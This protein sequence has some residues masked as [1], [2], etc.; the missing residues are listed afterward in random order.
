MRWRRGFLVIKLQIENLKDS[1]QY[2][3]SDLLENTNAADIFSEYFGKI[4]KD[5]LASGNSM[6]IQLPEKRR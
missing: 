4:W 2:S 3:Y 5:L 1:Y 6:K